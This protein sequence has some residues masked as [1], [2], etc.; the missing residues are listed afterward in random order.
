MFTVARSEVTLDV[1]RTS[2]RL[3]SSV[4]STGLLKPIS[5]AG[6]EVKLTEQRKKNGR[7]VTVKTASVATA[8]TGAYAW[9]YQPGRRGAYCIRTS[10]AAT[11]THTA[12][13]TKWVAFGVN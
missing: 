13:L 7:W 9:T 8:S 1:S 4:R 6:S 12:A 10:I 2:V 11:A 3:G 5:L